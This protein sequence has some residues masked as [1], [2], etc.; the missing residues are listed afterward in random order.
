MIPRWLS[1]PVGRGD[2][3]EWLDGLGAYFYTW[4]TE[5]K[6]WGTE[7][8]ALPRCAVL[9]DGCGTH[10]GTGKAPVADNMT[11]ARWGGTWEF[12]S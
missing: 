2:I 5:V 10:A 9:I 6:T 1:R 11:L 8:K 12:S 3:S 7:V 4:G